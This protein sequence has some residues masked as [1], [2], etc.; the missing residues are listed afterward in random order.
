M[1][2]KVKVNSS[3][4]K[5]ALLKI[6]FASIVLYTNG[7]AQSA[8]L[9][10]LYSE[11]NVWEYE[12]IFTSDIFR[13][14]ISNCVQDKNKSICDAYDFG[15]I[16]IQKDSIFASNSFTS[17]FSSDSNFIS[18]F[19]DSVEIDSIWNSCFNCSKTEEGYGTF[20]RIK[21]ISEEIVFGDTVHVYS[22]DISEFIN[23]NP[24]NFIPMLSVQFSKEFGIVGFQQ[25]EGEF[26]RL[27]GASINDNMYG[28]FT[29]NTEENTEPYFNLED[30]DSLFFDEF[31]FDGFWVRDYGLNIQLVSSDTLGA[32]QYAMVPF[33]NSKFPILNSLRIDN[34]RNVYASAWA[35][36]IDFS[37]VFI[38]NFQNDSTWLL[39]EPEPFFPFEYANYNG[40]VNTN[41][42]GIEDSVHGVTYFAVFDTLN[43]DPLP[44]GYA[45]WS[46][47]FGL[48]Y[49][50]N[51]EGGNSHRLK[52]VIA[53]NQSY[54][55]T[56]IIITSNFGEE[57]NFPKQFILNQNYPNPFN[58]STTISF[59]L[60]QN[61]KVNLY[62]FN[63][64]GQK[65]KEILSNQNLSLGIYSFLFEAESLP[66]GVY[67][68]QLET[69]FGY[70]TKKMTLI[71]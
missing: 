71:K 11:D 28:R 69:K 66:S 47:V 40:L 15:A 34:N 8:Q 23:S 24:E 53:N 18:F 51:S 30:G 50:S 48:T 1:R 67:M 44:R 33:G 39:A 62:I 2:F 3:K 35:E 6:I 58:P 45:E 64:L 7:P 32:T 42:F 36:N 61:T 49:F 57:Q 10:N 21:D 60:T 25:W 31:D 37:K 38:S 52:G 27:V 65:V 22:I 54:G 68:Y 70:I 56:S 9:S 16:I 19:I 59:E 13:I 29:V 12:G 41:T 5:L 14:E 20:G 55:N 63:I 17:S 26:Y 43:P 46:N 4:F